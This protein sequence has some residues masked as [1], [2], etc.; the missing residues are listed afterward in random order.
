M[1]DF[2]VRFLSS[3]A[4]F[5]PLILLFSEIDFIF[6]IVIHTLLTLCLWE[7]FRL[8]NF[9]EFLT[10]KDVNIQFLLSRQKI[11]YFESFLIIK[12]NFLALFLYFF[13]V[14]FIF[15]I[16]LSL[17][18]LYLC[19]CYK[20]DLLKLIGLIY[21]ACPFF[22]LILFRTDE[23]YLTYLFFILYYAILTDTFSY[24]SGKIIKGKKIFP[25]IS[26]GKTYSGTLGGIIIPCL[27]TVLFFFN[28]SDYFIIILTS[29]F[30]SIGVHFGDLLESYL[31]RLSYVK[32]SGNLIPGHGG[33]LD[34]FDG[35]LFLVNIFFIL[36]ILNFNFFFIM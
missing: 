9:K 10:I 24:L 23:N 17:I 6:M 36:K 28:K 18:L 34:R 21:C 20:K 15:V 12:I 4:L 30:F 5:I 1:N 33:V 3:I 22:L 31:K 7:F 11:S 14:N 29:I 25:K 27:I 19:F 32:D 8:L 26:S 13:S 35:I 16:L 2:Q